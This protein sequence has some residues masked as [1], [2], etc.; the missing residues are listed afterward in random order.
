MS[1]LLAIGATGVRA[2]QTALTTVGENIA[3]TGVAGYSRRS[4]TLNEV[5]AAGGIT[6]RALTSAGVVVAGIAR[7]GDVYRSAAVRD[8]GADLA[9][10]EAGNVWLDRIQTSLTGANLGDRLTG[11][12]TTA[13]ALAADPT[14]VPQRAVLLEQAGAL[15]GAFSATGRQLATGMAELDATAQAA[16]GQLDALGRALA[17]ANDGLGRTAPGGAAAAQLADQRDQ[18]LDRMSAIADIGVTFDPAGRATVT[19]GATGPAFVAG[20]NSGHVS[21]SRAGGVV[22][23]AVNLNGTVSAFTPA[24]GA[25]AGVREGAGRL[26]DTRASLDALATDFVTE[27]NAIQANGRD[28]DGQPGAA[29]FATGALPTDLTVTL[30]DPRGLAAAGIGG[31]ARDASNLA[32]LESSRGSHGWEAGITALVGGNAAA[33]E[34]RKLVADAQ[35]SI[36]DG[37]VTA[38]ASAS[39]VDLDSEAVD[40]LRFQQAYQ[41]SSR[42]IQVARE[43]MQTLLEI[44]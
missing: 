5:N 8:A 23:L 3:N 21:Y 38:Q 22:S 42:V 19:L 43:T 40:L 33:L 25:L 37:A 12:F 35:A 1:D 44:R 30:A 18:L 2:Y 17:Q 39:G 14:S 27:V 9:R 11:F 10:T 41:A 29:I 16:T 4:A 28:L 20:S 31:G 6:G 32:Q 15:A 7:A 26:A 34:Q 24:G 13:R 36:R